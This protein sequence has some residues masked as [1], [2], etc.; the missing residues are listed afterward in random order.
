MRI[1][2]L[3][4]D[5]KG[6]Y[7]FQ[8]SDGKKTLLS[9]SDYQSKKDCLN[10]LQETLV[11]LRDN[12]QISIKAGN[13]SQYYFEVANYSQ[14][15][16][17]Y[18]IEEASDV[19]VRLKEFVQ[20]SQTFEVIYEKTS[21]K[22]VS[23]KQLGLREEGYNFSQKSKS[24]QSGFEVL[25]PEATNYKYFH[26]NDANGK[27][28]LFSRAFDGNN[29]RRKAIRN[30]I[31]N[32]ENKDHLE[33]ITA[34]GKYFFIIKTSKGYEIARS[35]NYSSQTKLE[36]AL[37]F[38]QAE[39]GQY[40][41]G[42]KLTKKDK[43]KKKKKPK[44]KEK[45]HLK[46]IAPLGLDGFEGFKSKKNK[47]QYFHYH[48]ENGQVLLFSQPYESRSKRDAAIA[49][50]IKNGGKDK[51]FKTWKKSKNQ[52]YFSLMAKDGK[53]YARSP[54]FSSKTEMQT[55]LKKL[56]STISN[57]TPEVNYAPVTKQ[58][59]YEIDL[60]EKEISV[61][62]VPAVAIAVAAIPDTV[63][64]EEVAEAEAILAE[65]EEEEKLEM[66]TTDPVLVETEA[67]EPEGVLIE[68]DPLE[69]H[70][71]HPSP[72]RPPAPERVYEAPKPKAIPST[73]IIEEKPSSGFPWKWILIGLAAIAL[74]CLLRF[75]TMGEEKV[76]PAVTSPKPAIEKSIEKPTPS[77]PAKLGKT[78][79]DFKFNP[80]TAEG[81]IADFLSKPKVS[82]PRIF[83][84]ES[85]QFPFNSAALTPASHLQLDNVADVLK[86][87]PLAKIEV[88]GHTDSRGNDANNLTLSQNRAEAV[89]NYLFA[90]GITSNRIVKA[91]GFGE[92]N[93]SA[94]NDTDEGR[95]EN[96]RSEVVVVE[97]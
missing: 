31:K 50:S 51:A 70:I 93:P 21:Q 83:V 6:D 23:K 9:S 17:Y 4:P 57:I 59:I 92:S 87:Y 73:P 30:I 1:Q 75:C 72:T 45:Y 48:G 34:E 43:K 56:Q 97:R 80:A 22:E 64:P 38:L 60:P 66:E 8:I 58:K 20:S 2:L 28:I 26:F 55:V 16:S 19:L 61:P 10:Q 62:V 35:K 94:T 77:P 46:Q 52:Y 91:T 14:S 65:I 40:K 3:R 63:E 76:T 71:A 15:P 85:V 25:N 18:D 5:A 36:S 39:V 67:I 53:S 86:E 74:L 47:L 11:T 12:E 95:Q 54:Y 24:G 49:Y 37:T 29:K 44:A 69:E 78:A 33:S 7:L 82:L 41:Q 32:V 68:A 81:K 79:I 96:R 13:N 89:K 90:Q 88:N 42:F 84:L 27:A